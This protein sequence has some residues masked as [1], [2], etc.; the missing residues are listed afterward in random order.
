MQAKTLLL[1]LAFVL[2]VAAQGDH[3][4]VTNGDFTGT[5][6]PWVLGGGY[7]CTP[8]LDTTYATNGITVSDA[9][10]CGPG[11]Q[12]TPAPYP[13]NTLEQ[14]IT[15]VAGTTY[16]LR[17]DVSSSRATSS[18]TNADAGRIYAQVNGVEVAR[19]TY[20][21]I[22]INE[23]KRA[24][25]CGRWVAAASGPVQLVIFT[26]R[27]FLCNAGTPR[28]NIDNVSVEDV[29]G[30]TYCIVGNRKIGTTVSF[31]VSGQAGAAYA[32]FIAAGQITGGIPIPGFNGLWWLDF[33]S[34]TSFLSGA[35]DGAGNATTPVPIPN[36][37]ALKTVPLYH[38]AI[39]VGTTAELGL[40]FCVVFT[41]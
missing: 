30:P 33:A 22:I 14:T 37:T 18:G 28:V 10:G 6:V 3:N 36:N 7:S 8:G 27:S 2:P 26:E 29:T 38:Q 1:S 11:G 35:L 39:S 16:E 4:L 24:H 40:C 21:S 34:V 20:G 5:L 9:F 13:A 41:N 32:T 12:V 23:T 19:I 31:A 15:L 17:A 25:L